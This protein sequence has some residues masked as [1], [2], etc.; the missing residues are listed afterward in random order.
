MRATL[1]LLG[2]A[3]LLG[4]MASA[5]GAAT[6]TTNSAA[7]A[8]AAGSTSDGICDSDPGAPV[9][10][11]LRAAIQ[12]ANS[13]AAGDLIVLPDLGPDYALSLGGP[14]ENAALGGDLDITNP[15]TIQGSGGATINGGGIDRVLHLGPVSGAPALTLITLEVR[16]GGNNAV[17]GGI[18]VERGT[19]ALDRVTIDANNAQAGGGNAAGGGLWIASAGADSIT[20]STITGNGASGGGS[21]IA[22]GVG[23]QNPAVSLQVVNSTISDNTATSA[24]GAAEGGGLWTAAPVALTYVTLDQNGANGVPDGVGGNLRT[25]GPAM[26]LRA[27]IVSDGDAG[28]GTQNCEGNFSSLGY[29]IEGQVDGIGQCGLVSSLGDKTA[30]SALLAPLA[31][32]GGPTQTHALLNGSPAVDSVPS[33]YP[34]AVDQ[35][36]QRRPSAF[37][38]DAGSFERQ[39]LAPRAPCFG[40]QPTM[41]GFAQDESIVGTPL[42]DVIVGGAGNDTIN[43][44][45]GKDRICGG[46]GKDRI[47]GGPGD[48]R[49]AGEEDGDR[50]FGKAGK[51]RLEGGGGRDLLNG[52]KGRD[53]IDG[54]SRR[55]KC[56]GAK[57]DRVADC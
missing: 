4:W 56:R 36:G 7:D 21:A 12:E 25:T 45:G 24:L 42:A 29:N 9:V 1:C 48:D 37:A 3:C 13:D 2:C 33:C 34:L 26:T 14:G 19:I 43:G 6:Y 47:V 8:A 28:V 57:K 39:V 15:L 41:F 10:C 31:D 30:K 27:S 23:V 17:G 38:C 40:Q 5:A 44:L 16:G 18:F 55:D 50:L 54:G 49:L 11:T 46:S 20:A 51:D 22:A 35:R 53:L 52:G 32:R